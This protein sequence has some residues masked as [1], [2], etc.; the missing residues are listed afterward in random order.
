MKPRVNLR[1]NRLGK[2][3]EMTKNYTQVRKD[4]TR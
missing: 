2:C 3:R 1:V 4:E